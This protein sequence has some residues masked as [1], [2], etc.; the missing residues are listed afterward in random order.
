LLDIEDNVKKLIDIYKQVKHDREQM[1]SREMTPKE[2]ALYGV[3]NRLPQNVIYK[4]LERYHYIDF[5][6]KLKDIMG[7]DGHITKEKIVDIKTIVNT[8]T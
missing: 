2:I 6:H 8:T 3:K 7:K 5:L 4:M 1:F